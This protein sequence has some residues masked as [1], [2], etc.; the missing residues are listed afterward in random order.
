[1]NKNNMTYALSIENV[2]KT[3]GGVKRINDLSVRCQYGKIY[4]LIGPNGAGKTT[5]LK[6][7]T[8]LYR[9][10]EGCVKVCGLDPVKDY[11]EVRKKFGLLPQ[12][13]ALYP[14]L[15]ARQ[16]LQFHGALY[17]HDQKKLN[18]RIDEI[19]KLIDL[20]DRAKEPVKNYSGGMKR[21][22]GI[23]MA[24]LNDPQLIFF[25]EPTLGVDVHNSHRIWEYIRNLKAQNKTVIVTTNVMSE[26]E[27]LC[28]EIFI[29]NRGEKVCEG[30][31]DELKGSLGS[32]Y[33]EI[34]TG[35]N[36]ESAYLE[37]VIGKYQAMNENAIRV[38]APNGEQDLLRILEQAKGRI[39]IENIALKKPTLDDVFIHYTGDPMEV[40][41]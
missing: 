38:D 15:S 31:P 39:K 19:L 24:L 28:D 36:Y 21:R 13:T 18:A 10:D 34:L 14:E 37:A 4:G 1:M 41:N 25:D 32:G 35:E 6:L 8:G 26:A 5:F 17:F 20:A 12:E 11:K 23:G 27:N 7:I 22:L 40:R 29:I 2:S 9:A 3:L 33:I 30:T 16:N